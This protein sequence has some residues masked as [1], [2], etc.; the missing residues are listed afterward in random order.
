[1]T[2][3]LLVPA[4]DR[5]G[6]DT[7]FAWCLRDGR[8]QA[9]REGAGPLAS[10]PRGNA[11][12]AVL[13][14]SRVLFARLRL[15][16]VN[17][18]TIRELL[19]FAVEDRLLAD[20]AHIH[21]VPGATNARGETLVAVVDR[22]WLQEI[23]AI[24]ARAGLAPA[25]VFCETA[26]VPSERGVWHA[27]L[28]AGRS[29]LVEDDGHAVAFDRP[30]GTEPPLAVRIAA[31]EAAE[32]GTRPGQLRVLVEPGLPMPDAA[33]WGERTGMT[34]TAA[35]SPLPLA[36][37][38]ASTAIDLQVGD[39]ARRAPL[40]ASPRVPPLAWGLAAAIVV[41][42]LGFTAFDWWRLERER[43]SLEAERESIFRSAF[44]EAKTVV[45]PALQMRRNLAELQ[46]AHGRA[47]ASDFLALATA[48]AKSDPSP[49][50]RIT[51]AGGR[52]EVDRGGAAK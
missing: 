6:I 17:A 12:E 29:F 32:R 39:F 9:S 31:A 7:P 20:P 38:A 30:A 51:Y 10:V 2:L 25:R 43:R 5:P 37:A 40:F 19:P 8:G 4:V 16:K 44:P 50:R 34:V 35:E 45:D 47:S 1:M 27:V 15:P 26:L 18:A 11:V 14:A 23:L 42:Q 21:A 49:A 33:A 3:R 36:A 28:G 46:R 24:L 13:P 22:A 52:F 41:V 48:A